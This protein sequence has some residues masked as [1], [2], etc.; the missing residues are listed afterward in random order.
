MSGFGQHNN[1]LYLKYYLVVLQ[2]TR[3]YFVSFNACTGHI[4]VAITTNYLSTRQ[5]STQATVT[6]DCI[7][8]HI[9]TLLAEEIV[10]P[11]RLYCITQRQPNNFNLIILVNCNFNSFNL[12]N[13]YKLTKYKFLKLPEGVETCRS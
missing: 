4:I 9:N 3:K 10:S 11:H 8:S 6:M 12:N 13:L 5:N 1:I 7:Y 2:E